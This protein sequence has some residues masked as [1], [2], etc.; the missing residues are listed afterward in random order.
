MDIGGRVR[1]ILR[2]DSAAYAVVVRVV[3]DVGV[4]EIGAVAAALSRRAMGRCTRGAGVTG[5]V[6]EGEVAISASAYWAMAK[7]RSWV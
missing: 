7:A 3:G 2:D 4:E 6:V 1:I 5:Q